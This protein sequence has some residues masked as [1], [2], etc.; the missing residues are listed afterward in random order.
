MI[1]GHR[2]TLI[3]GAEE[4]RRKD[5]QEKGEEKANKSGTR[6]EEPM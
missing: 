2:S 3:P 5:R 1:R 4:G 6:P